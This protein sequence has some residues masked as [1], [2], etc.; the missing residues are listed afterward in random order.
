MKS[1]I[2]IP[3]STLSLAYAPVQ[4][5][6]EDS[7]TGGT[8]RNMLDGAR[9]KEIPEKPSQSA[10]AEADKKSVKPP[11]STQ[12]KETAKPQREER[13]TK[14][15]P[16][17]QPMAMAA[18]A[19]AEM[20]TEPVLQPVLQEQAVQLAA[21]AQP[22]PAQAASNLFI[23]EL[24]P[25]QA[26]PPAQTAKQANSPIVTVIKAQAMPVE[27]EP[28]PSY[29]PV[30]V[31][32]ERQEKFDQMV[33][34]AA[35]KLLQTQSA[36]NSTETGAAEQPQELLAEPVTAKAA[37]KP[38]ETEDAGNIPLK[39]E[40]ET[41][42]ETKNGETQYSFFDAEPQRVLEP[43]TVRQEPSFRPLSTPPPAEQIQVR[44]LESLE[45]EKMEF[46]M[47]LQPEEL[48]KISVKM[49]LEGG[50]LT[51]EVVTANAKA[52]QALAKQTDGLMATLK[53]TGMQVE[54]VQ[55]TAQADVS[56]HMENAFNMSA[57]QNGAGR[58]SQ[59]AHN[60]AAVTRQ[61]QD[62]APIT[63]Q[64]DTAPQQLLNYAV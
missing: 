13:P 5:F 34:R 53:A 8:F 12:K 62:D 60:G 31:Q 41:V 52:A 50:R 46:R 30:N 39:A 23:A 19:M 27:A 17:I 6:S 33:T 64:S 24:P 54:S 55:V 1:A 35:Q 10:S 9:Q 47:Q 15:E 26:E 21:A 4:S 11:R 44:L 22:T 59:E 25:A 20:P 16:D 28:A 38:R 45:A 63:I 36:A 18:G 51:V 58:H 42:K 29:R 40:R 57:F 48:G 43:F 49:V 3:L 61:K 32:P 2:V 14:E 37:A 7:F 56:G